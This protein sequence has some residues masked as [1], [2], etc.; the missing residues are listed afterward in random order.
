MTDFEAASLALQGTA[1]AQMFWIGIGQIAV[2]LLGLALIHWEG[3]A[4]A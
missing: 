4:R 3:S 2:I 1:S